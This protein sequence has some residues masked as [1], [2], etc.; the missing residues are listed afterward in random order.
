MNTRPGFRVR[1]PGPQGGNLVWEAV[2]ALRVSTRVSL[3]LAIRVSV[4]NRPGS[5]GN[6]NLQGEQMSLDLM[7]AVVNPF[8]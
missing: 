6:C 7:D 8:S 2:V 1:Y 3:V 5:S 4:G